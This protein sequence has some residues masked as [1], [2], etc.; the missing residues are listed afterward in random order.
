MAVVRHRISMQETNRIPEWIRLTMGLP[1]GRRQVFAVRLAHIEDVNRPKVGEA[2][3]LL[4]FVVFLL[5]LSFAAHRRQ[6]HNPLLAPLDVSM[7]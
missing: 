4:V 6:D 7:H 3:G 5:A 2:G 1:N